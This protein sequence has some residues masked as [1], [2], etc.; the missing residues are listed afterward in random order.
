MFKSESFRL[1]QKVKENKMKKLRMLI[2]LLLPVS[3]FLA[4][5]GKETGTEMES[6]AENK[7]ELTIYTT[8]YPLQFF[9][10]EIGKE[11]VNV[12]SIYP[13]GADEHSFEP[14][15]KDMMKLAD[16]DLFI[17]VGL[18]LEG[19]VNKAEQTLKDENV[20]LLAAGE[21]IQFD[22]QG[23]VH[24]E[25]HEDDHAEETGHDHEEEADHEEE[26]GHNH[27]DIDPHVWIDPV[28]ASKLAESIKDELVNQLP[29]NKEQLEENYQVL[30][31]QLDDLHN[32]FETAIDQAKHKEFIVSHAAYGYWEDRYGIEQI[33]IAGLSSTAEPSQK[34][35]QTIISTAK[36]H[37]LKYIFFE[38]NISSKLAEMVQN[39]INATPL[40]LHNLSVLTD[41]DIS[42]NRTYIT[43]MEDNLKALE[44]ALNE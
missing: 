9:A 29:E 24:E 25:A 37:D 2:L 7:N 11:L 1:I 30:V 32:Q 28:Y 34:E 42:N 14:S 39:E 4:G 21:H 41:D 38:Q 13:P 8:V 12:E 23:E 20:T 26:D 33:S 15:Q 31:K 40:V 36:K 10:E 43:I 16:S 17:Y 44:K 18:G 22:N 5:C 3:L 6:P 35:L 27:G 19:F